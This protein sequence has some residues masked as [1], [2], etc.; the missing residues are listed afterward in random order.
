[1]SGLTS[2]TEGAALSHPRPELLAATGLRGL[3]GLA[4]VASTVGVWRG[5][6]GY[7][8]DLITVTALA[9]VPFFLLLSGFVL[10]YN[11]PGL[12]YASGRRVIGRYAMARIARI[13]PL[14]V[15]AGLAVLM[16][17]ALNGSDW[18]R[19]VYADQTWFVG[20]LV[21]CYLVYPL[22]ARVVAAAPGRA[23]LVSLAV[24]GALA[25]VQ[26]TTSIALD[27]FP[28][29]WLPV[30]TLGMALAGR[31]LPAP[32]WPA[33]PLLVRLGVIGYPLFLLHAL[34]LHGFGPVHAGT[35]S[36][37]LLALGWIGLT[38]FVAEGAHRYVGVPARRGILDLA[39]RSARL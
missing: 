22:L 10:A 24:A 8:Q 13:V 17:G 3:A 7:L 14:F 6:P 4:V 39:R 2:V 11:Y 9:A 28:P 20:T 32:R 21:L 29:A 15:I 37:A 27:R 16:L 35:L 36:N 12:S 34:V 1:M 38:V 33:H 5:A 30:F 19:A 31:E 26:L 18:V 25:A 23:A